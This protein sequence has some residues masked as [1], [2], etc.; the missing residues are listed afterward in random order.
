MYTLDSYFNRGGSN[1]AIAKLKY[2]S[3]S[4]KAKIKQNQTKHNTK[5]LSQKLTN[6]FYAPDPKND[7]STL[8]NQV[9]RQAFEEISQQKLAEAD[10]SVGGSGYH[11]AKTPRVNTSSIHV[12]AINNLIK[13]IELH[14]ELLPSSKSIE[15][16]DYK[17]TALE[18]ETMEAFNLIQEVLNEMGTSISNLSLTASSSFAGHSRL[19]IQQAYNTLQAFSSGLK[20]GKALTKTD[21]GNILEYA[22][23]LLNEDLDFAEEASIQELLDSLSQKVVGSTMT[24]RTSYGDNFISTRLDAS[25]LKEKAGITLSKNNNNVYEFGGITLRHYTNI[26][27]GA[28]KYGKID[29]DQGDLR[30]S[31]KNWSNL[32]FKNWRTGEEKALRS[33]GSAS[34]VDAISRTTDQLENYIWNMQDPRGGAP[35]AGH[36]LAKMA[37]YTDIIMGFGNQRAANILLINN[38]AGRE[39]I[40]VDISSEILN[41]LNGDNSK[42]LLNGYEGSSISSTARRLMEAVQKLPEEASQSGVYNT[43]MLDYLHG[44]RA[45]ILYNH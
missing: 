31:A 37:L 11:Y 25:G 3:T 5:V 7:S 27:P 38:H 23:G 24:S 19:S 42:F 40:V 44:I 30:I 45:S 32:T 36:S 6:L 8:F 12:T 2:A 29:V 43:T 39:V 16:I 22:I 35:E 26:T 14:I 15:E 13:T 41:A 17:V 21:M 10:F 1:T 33:I 34:L 4:L 20:T 28:K 18:K 9:L